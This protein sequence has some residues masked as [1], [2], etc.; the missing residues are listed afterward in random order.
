M[1]WRATVSSC[2]THL[3]QPCCKL[4]PRVQ[5]KLTI[6]CGT[7]QL[8]THHSQCRYLLL[9]FALSRALPALAA[10]IDDASLVEL[11]D[12]TLSSFQELLMFR[13][14]L[15]AARQVLRTIRAKLLPHHVVGSVGPGTMPEL[16]LY[17][18]PFT[19][20]PGIASGIPTAST[21]D[22]FISF[23]TPNSPHLFPS[24]AFTSPQHSPSISATSSSPSPR[25]ATFV[26]GSSSRMPFRPETMA[27]LASA[28]GSGSMS[29]GDIYPSHPHPHPRPEPALPQASFPVQAE[30]IPSGTADFD[31]FIYH[32]GLSNL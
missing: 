28:S 14:I 32:L 24:S 18:P 30:H 10:F 3:G 1:A 31:G 25:S 21:M 13:S 2:P 8:L 9:L 26:S 20:A 15:E 7:Q 23:P 4:F 17:C 12:R 22:S 27:A 6:I 19:T 5:K 11:I 29:P 16:S